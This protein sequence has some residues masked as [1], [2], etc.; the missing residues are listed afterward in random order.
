MVKDRGKAIV[1]GISSLILVVGLVLIFYLQPGVTGQAIS[2]SGTVDDPYTGL[3]CGFDEWEENKH[4]ILEE[5]IT[6]SKSCF[7][8]DKPGVTLDCKKKGSIVGNAESNSFG[9]IVTAHNVHIV[10]CTITNF[11]VG[12]SNSQYDNFKFISNNVLNNEVGVSLDRNF[13]SDRNLVCANSK[14]DIVCNAKVSSLNAYS[15]TLTNLDCLAWKD[16]S[17]VACDN[18]IEL[19]CIDGFDN[20][21]NGDVDCDD[22]DCH[23]FCNTFDCLTNNDITSCKNKLTKDSDSDGVFDYADNC[24]SDSNKNQRDNDNDGKGDSCDDDDD[25]DGELD[26]ADN[27]PLDA[28]KDQ[29]DTDSDK[30]GDACDDDDDGDEVPD[31]TDNCPINANKN[32]MDLDKDS[33]G[34]VCDTDDDG[35]SILDV[36]DNCPRFSNVKQVDTDSDGAGDVCDDDDDGDEAP[37]SSDNC[38]VIANKDQKDTDSDKKGDACDVCPNDATDKCKE[39]TDNDGILGT[40]DLCSTSEGDKKKAAGLIASNGCVYG[41]VAGKGGVG[42]SDG[43]IDDFDLTKLA[44]AL[45]IYFG[46]TCDKQNNPTFFDGDVVGK[47]GVGNSDGCIDDFDLSKLAK[48]YTDNLNKWKCG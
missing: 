44:Q 20:N 29:T 3:E 42:K 2:G 48:T 10:G 11:F 39:D 33:Y 37:D 4:Y 43:C 22:S 41:D 5:K 19:S 6:S 28:N 25:N 18:N 23:D 46:F 32:Q 14:Q 27:C 9:I 24:L 7:T 35:D 40:A 45:P 31:A 13:L 17:Q 1:I 15:N 21:D 26:D 36:K 38:P 47:Q 34:D 30:K 12:A 8:I 16:E